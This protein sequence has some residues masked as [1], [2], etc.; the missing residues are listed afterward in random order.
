MEKPPVLARN[1]KVA[2]LPMS[3][4]FKHNAR[5]QKLLFVERLLSDG[6]AVATAGRFAK[7]SLH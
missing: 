3:V 4:L 5:A 7:V 1:L 2:L 6:Y